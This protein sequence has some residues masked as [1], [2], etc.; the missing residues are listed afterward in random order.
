MRSLLCLAFCCTV[1]L[2]AADKSGVEDKLKQLEQEWAQAGVK[3]D[4]AAY[5]RLEADD[6]MFTD[7]EGHTN[8]KAQDL[9][10]LKGKVFT[11]QGMDL[12][13][14]KVRVLG[15]AAV[16][17][18]RTT[19]KGGKYKDQDISGQ[20]RFTDVWANRGGHW[21]VV[22]SQATQIKK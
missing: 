8:G 22:A 15:T 21:Q 11:A 3:G 2:A 7:P 1:A 13:D 18:G 6:F 16:I 19:I 17:T 12:D 4:A 20:Y 10:D 9:S 5:E 14:L